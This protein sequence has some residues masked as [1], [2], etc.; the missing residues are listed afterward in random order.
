MPTVAKLEMPAGPVWA[1]MKQRRIE[2]MHMLCSWWICSIF[3]SMSAYV[4][5]CSR[6][7]EIITTNLM[8][9]MC[10]SM[11]EASRLKLQ[12]VSEHL[13][14]PRFLGTPLLKLIG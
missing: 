11:R 9:L 4:L 13:Y 2:G 5:H 10:C 6:P 12:F 7:R 3:F 1:P 14:F 8:F